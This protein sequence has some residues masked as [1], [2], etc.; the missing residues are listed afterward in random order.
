M[1]NGLKGVINKR[2]F[3]KV[4][5]AVGVGLRDIPLISDSVQKSM[6]GKVD[7]GPNLQTAQ[8]YQVPASQSAARQEVSQ[9]AAQARTAA[10]NKRYNNTGAQ[11]K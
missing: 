4:K 5:R 3:G 1:D 7:P 9:R 11:L 10:R 6:S 8:P 2:L